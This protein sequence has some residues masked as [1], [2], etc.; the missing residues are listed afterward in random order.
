MVSMSDIT[1]GIA[2]GAVVA[3]TIK[4]YDN[5]SKELNSAQT[6]FKKFG[7]SLKAFGAIAITAIGAFTVKALEAAVESEKVSF[8]VKK[9]F[10]EMADEV[11]AAAKRMQDASIHTDEEI[12]QSFVDLQT[13]TA[14]LGLTFQQQSAIIQ[15]GLDLAAKSGKDFAS[16]NDAIA[17][18]LSGRTMGLK[19]LGIQLKEGATQQDILNALTAKFAEVQGASSEETKTFYGQVAI[20]KRQFGDVFEDVGMQL[21]PIFK[22]LAKIFIDNKDII[23]ELAVFIGG[24]LVGAFKILIPTAKIIAGIFIEIANAIALVVEGI[25]GLYN[26]ITKGDWSFKGAKGIAGNM[27][28][29]A[30]GNFAPSFGGEN[31]QATEDTTYALQE[32]T[33]SQNLLNEGVLKT[34]GNTKMLTETISANSQMS[35]V[36]GKT[37]PDLFPKTSAQTGATAQLG[38]TSNMTTAYIG[39]LNNAISNLSVTAARV[40]GGGKGTAGS[41]ARFRGDAKLKSKGGKVG[42]E[43]FWKL[44]DLE[45]EGSTAAT[46]ALANFSS[47]NDFVMRPGQEPISF[48]SQDTI[49]GVKN[50]GSL[51]GGGGMTV[52]INGDIYGTDPQQIAKALRSELYGMVSM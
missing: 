27:A 11:E 29:A 52:N 9:S 50:P 15:G 8:R 14:N 49:I 6:G 47:F 28:E 7:V 36:Y 25:I 19:A 34:T 45:S 24:A 17:A 3:I 20:L 16:V 22:D 1:G 42:S 46:K 10:G 21:I 38:T 48:S 40:G 5:Y 12:G 23:K 4:A 41:E 39:N 26:G 32:Q 33:S 44:I 13:R 43:N 51:G 35:T 31:T 18:G 37:L 30:K 2:G